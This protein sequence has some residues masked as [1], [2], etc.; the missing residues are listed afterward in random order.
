MRTVANGCR[1]QVKAFFSS[2]HHLIRDVFLIMF[3][4]RT[5][6][7]LL[8]YAA[9]LLVAA[10]FI[11]H[12]FAPPAGSIAKYDAHCDSSGTGG[13]RWF[14]F[15]WLSSGKCATT[16]FVPPRPIESVTGPAIPCRENLITIEQFRGRVV[17]RAVVVRFPTTRSEYYFVQFRWFYRSWLESEMF[18]LERWR[19]D[20]I[21]LIDERFSSQT[22][23]SLEKL[24]CRVKNERKNR[25]QISRCIL[26]E[27]QK[28]SQR[29]EST[30]QFYRERFPFFNRT[31]GLGENVDRLFAIYEYGRNLNET[32]ANLYNLLLVTTMNT[33]LTTQF[34]KYIP[35]RC[36]FLLGASPDYS[37]WYS[38]TD[39]ILRFAHALLSTLKEPYSGGSIDYLAAIRQLNSSMLFVGDQ[40][41]IPCDSTKTTYRTSIYHLKCYSHSTGLFSERMFRENAYDGFDKEPF[42]I[43][44][45]RE[46]AAF[47][48]L[49]SK[50]IS[51]ESLQALAVN[52]TRRDNSN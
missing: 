15:G 22:R 1:R 8:F 3:R 34:G 25:R 44:I 4:L 32:Q 27:H 35:L 31:T 49:Q 11:L 2:I 33:F 12:S 7:S 36:A 10:V 5:V 40:V 46:Y 50:V 16:L 20:L 14:P 48:A 28:F 21:V 17:V 26:V 24:N 45:A 18:T 42:N 43:Y 41:D 52:V 47:I 6:S 39:Q 38:K 13:A 30:R 29:S 19:T 23:A 37:T 9:A 51:L